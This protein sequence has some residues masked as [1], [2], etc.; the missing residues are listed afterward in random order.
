M[1]FCVY[2]GVFRYTA[3]YGVVVKIKIKI[4]HCEQTI[5]DDRYLLKLKQ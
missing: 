1:F 4:L 3:Y 5:Q 2:H